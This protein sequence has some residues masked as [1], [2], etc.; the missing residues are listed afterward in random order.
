MDPHKKPAGTME[1]IRLCCRALENKKAE[2]LKVL[3][4][5]GLSSIT[6]T[7][8]LATGT[9]EPHLRAL[10]NELEKILK[11]AR[12][13]VIGE[14]RDSHTGW[15][16]LDAFDFMIHLFTREKRDFY[17]L[18]TLWKDAEEIEPVTEKISA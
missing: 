15:I 6:D 9:S 2:G 12:V 11:E 16:V 4:V 14:E 1:E 3:N 18:D 5:E 17:R 8:I 7:M 13:Q 10:R